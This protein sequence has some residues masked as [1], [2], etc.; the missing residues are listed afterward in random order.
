MFH[1]DDIRVV[2]IFEAL[3]ERPHLYTLHGGYLETISYMEGF[4]HGFTK[5]RSDA[6]L[7]GHYFNDDITRYG[8]F[9]RWLQA[10][11]GRPYKA[12]MAAIADH[13]P[14]PFAETLRQYR[15]FKGRPYEGD[16]CTTDMGDEYTTDMGND[17]EIQ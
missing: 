15:L 17:Q 13:Y 7:G 4:Y 12:A 8:R 11:S 10:T 14:D 16:E 9:R 6:Q 1:E 3:L 2:D 5:H